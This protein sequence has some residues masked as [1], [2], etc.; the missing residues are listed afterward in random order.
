MT[1]SLHSQVM[2]FDRYC[3]VAHSVSSFNQKIRSK[4]VSFTLMAVVWVISGAMSLPALIY[5]EVEMGDDCR[6]VA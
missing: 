4:R 1:H 6:Y 5:S 2:A 3:A